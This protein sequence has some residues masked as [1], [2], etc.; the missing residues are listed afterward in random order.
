[1]LQGAGREDGEEERESLT[2]HLE[3]FFLSAVVSLSPRAHHR[4]V[5]EEEEEKEE[6]DTD[7]V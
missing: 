2:E 1:M 7:L 5:S 4:R 6:G 3:G